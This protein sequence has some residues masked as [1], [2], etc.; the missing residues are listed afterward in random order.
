MF[1][2]TALAGFGLTVGY[3]LVYLS[4]GVLI[5]FAAIAVNVAGP[6][7]GELWALATSPRARAAYQLT[8]GGS[9]RVAALGV[10]LGTVLAWTL[11]HRRFRGREMLDGLVDMPFAVPTAVA[12][13][14]V[15]AVLGPSGQGSPLVFTA[16]LVVLGLPFV[17]RTVQPVFERRAPEGTPAVRLL[18]PG[19]GP[20]MLTGFALAFARALA[21]YGAVLFVAGTRHDDLARA[22]LLRMARLEQTA[23]ASATAVALVLL[24]TALALLLALRGL[25][26]R[27]RAGRTARARAPVDR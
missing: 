25:D 10:G 14:A 18:A 11:A 26:A 15:L 17:V 19:L 7:A 9:L 8:F 27:C 12:G 23:P 6:S 1:R 3:T 13:L 2:T 5:L 22:P 24:V 4:L 20:A 21:E 16:A